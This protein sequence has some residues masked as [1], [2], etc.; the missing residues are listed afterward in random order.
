M[1]RKLVAWIGGVLAFLALGAALYL[2]RL[3]RE[4]RPTEVSVA[5][6]T[7][8]APLDDPS[9][10]ISGLAWWHDQLVLMPQ[11]PQR[12]GDRL[13]AI[14]RAAIDAYVDHPSTAEP[15]EVRPVELDT[16]GLEDRIVGFDGFEALDFAGHDVYFAVEGD[17]DET[18]H[19]GFVVRGRV[20]GRLERVVLEPER[21]SPIE[22]Q[23]ELA[24]TGYEA[25][26]VQGD[27]VLA[28]YETNG[29]VNEAPRVMSFDRELRRSNDIALAPIEYRVT[30][31]TAMD[32][33]GRF[34]VANYHWPGAPW[35]PGVCSLTERYGQ[36]E[37]HARCRTVERLV[38]LRMTDQ[39]IGPTNRAPIQ[40]ELVDDEHARNWEGVV[41][42]GDRGFL[43][44]TDEHPETILA[45][46]PR[47]RD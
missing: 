10:E 12:H 33:Q 40:L 1:D 19:A 20:E 30:D 15:L 23:N 6:I 29:E 18:E 4:N 39:G 25:L 38:E 3:P 42:L 27:R 16:R 44:A 7:L 31:A 13:F 5:R 43:L 2:F 34:W 46:V 32:G 9:V 11:Y 14:S 24:N 28:L 17:R 47:P 35:S 36:G 22:P 41:R 45:F 8:A 26:L 21:V 37:S